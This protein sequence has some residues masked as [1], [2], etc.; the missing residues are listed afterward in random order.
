MKRL[1]L[2]T[3]S[4]VLLL[5]G[6]DKESIQK[7]AAPNETPAAPSIAY[8]P[9]L[10]LNDEVGPFSLIRLDT[11]KILAYQARSGTM[12][13][14]DGVLK[15]PESPDY[16]TIERAYS[17]GSSRYVLIVSTG[18]FGLSC[19]AAT[20]VL[21]FDTKQEYVDG[22]SEIE[23][24][25]QIVESLSEENKLTIKKDGKATIVYNGIVK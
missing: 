15:Y 23:G 5:A 21:S 22:H 8:E 6:C 9:L 14:L 17:F 7:D 13:L 2:F 4:A 18:E 3:A 19:P 11:V 25:S 20:Y 24:C 16:V 1:L 10:I 12:N